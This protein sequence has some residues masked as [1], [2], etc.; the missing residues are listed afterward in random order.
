MSHVTRRLNKGEISKS[1]ADIEYKKLGERK[2]ELQQYIKYHRK[3]Y[4]KKG[5][6][7]KPFGK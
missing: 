2:Q 3:K 5:S 4:P 7:I 1:Q 6:G